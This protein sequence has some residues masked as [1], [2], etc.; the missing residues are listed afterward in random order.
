MRNYFIIIFMAALILACGCAAPEVKLFTDATT[1]LQ[2]FI[3]QGKE[4]GKVLVIPISGIISDNPK[5]RFMRTMPS[6]VQEVVSQLRLAEKDDEVK[7][8]LLKIETPGGSTTASDL[9]YHEIMDFKKRKNVKI[10]VSMMGVATSGGYYISLPADFIMAHPTTVT[11]SVGV[12]FIRPVM[13]NLMNKI[14]LDID[15]NKSGENKDMGSPFRLA[16][17]EEQKILQSM[18][19]ELGQRFTRLVA[20]HRKI[21][22]EALDKISTGRVYLAEEAHQLGLIDKIGYLSDAILQAKR[23]SGLSENAKVVAYRRT[24][25]PNDNLYNISTR[26][27]NTGGVSLIDLGFP[28]ALIPLETGFYYLWSPALKYRSR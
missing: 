19:D 7:A 13:A 6:M 11:G 3:L 14:G 9:L 18:T 12:I 20:K 27:L 5:E 22:K 10:V 21:D 4:E 15:I 25:Y 2:E 1:P 24:E 17:I 26:Q 16:T 28:D 23:L 8:I